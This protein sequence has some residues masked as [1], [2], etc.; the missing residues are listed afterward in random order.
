MKLTTIST[1]VLCSFLVVACG[2][3]KHNDNSGSNVVRQTEAG[4]LPGDASAPALAPSGQQVAS[5]KIAGPVTTTD[6]ANAS[7]SSDDIA[8]LLAKYPDFGRDV[9]TLQSVDKV[10]QNDNGMIDV[11]SGSNLLF[12]LAQTGDTW[13]VSATSMTFTPSSV[14]VGM[15]AVGTGDQAGSDVN[16][17]TFGFHSC[18]AGQQQNGDQNGQQEQGKGKEVSQPKEECADITSVIVLTKEEQKQEQQQQGG[19]E[20]PGPGQ[21]GTEQPKP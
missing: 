3:N 20:Q 18:V 12:T 9:T 14:L 16:S 2:K 17:L 10:V 7:A 21:G 6:N 4:P 11:Y 15:A 1:L 8:A 13:A 5:Y 19:K